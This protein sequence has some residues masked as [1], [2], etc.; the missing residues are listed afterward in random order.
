[1]SD[2]LQDERSMGFF[3]HID[4]LRGRL[5][6]SVFVFLIG[7]GI[8]YGLLVEPVMEFLKQPLF[9]NFPP[10]Q[11]KLYFTN[12]FENFLT[13]LKISA[14]CGLFGFSPY[15]F[16]ELWGFIAPGLYPHERKWVFPFVFVASLFFIGGA[17]FA[18]YV[19]FPVGFKFFITFGSETDVPLLT[20]DAY[21]S[22]VLKLLLLFGIVFELPVILTFL[23]FLGLVD[24]KMLKRQRANAIIG[25][26][27]MSAFFA[28]PDAVSMLLMMGPLF[29]LYEGSIWAV[30]LI[31]RKRAA[32]ESATEE[33]PAEVV[34]QSHKDSVRRDDS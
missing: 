10:E 20:I 18:Y 34:P 22:T 28:P 3:D 30:Q 13:H 17:A 12:L 6:R 9:L 1:M 27:V 16:F 15:F 11:Q 4:E 19:V 31:G 8:C 32:R 5:V 14:Y 25:I 26:T 7:F 33:K 24:A 29:L 21:F 23:G 2:Q